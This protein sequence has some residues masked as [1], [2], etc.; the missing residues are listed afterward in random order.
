MLIA[1]LGMLQRLKQPNDGIKWVPHENL[2]LLKF[3][4]DVDNAEILMS[5]RQYNESA[6]ITRH[7]TDFGGTGALA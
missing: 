5:A 4:G 2:H 1:T 6:Q 7:S 3:L